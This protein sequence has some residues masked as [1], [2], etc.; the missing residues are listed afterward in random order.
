[1]TCISGSYPSADPTLRGDSEDGWWQGGGRRCRV[2]SHPPGI[3]SEQN[4]SAP[5]ASLGLDVEQGSVAG[6]HGAREGVAE[7]DHGADG[8]GG[9]N[10]ELITVCHADRTHRGA[11]R[12]APSLPEVVDWTVTTPPTRH[13]ARRR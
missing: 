5:P 3:D 1:M 4:R 6:E 12:I 10:D 11:E 9:E 2:L 13:S 7:L 8:S